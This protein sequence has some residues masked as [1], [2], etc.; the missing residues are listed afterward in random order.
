MSSLA[1][2]VVNWEVYDADKKKIG[3]MMAFLNEGE[4][5][6]WKEQFIQAAYDTAT[7]SGTHMT[8]WIFLCNLRAAFQPHNNPAD[9][10]AQLQTLQFNLSKNIDKHITKFKIALARTKLDKS[11]DSQATIVFFK[12]TLLP[13]LI[14]QILGAENVPKTLSSWYKMATFQEQNW[15][16]IHEMFGKTT[17]SKNVNNYT[18]QK[19]NFQTWWDPNT[20]DVDVLTANQRTEMMKNG[21]CF[22]CKVVENLSQDCPNKKK[23]EEPKKEEKKKWKEKGLAAHVWALMLK[24]SAEEKNTFYEDAQDQCFWYEGLS[25][26]LPLHHYVFSQSLQGKWIKILYPFP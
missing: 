23:K 25:Q 14:Q 7:S 13:W 3:F 2:L 9:A 22:N 20:M 6:A 15:R 11:D 21:A 5:R 17:Q 18:S 24:I 8:F 10:L 12:E 16:E 1:H 4:V 19:F 26:H